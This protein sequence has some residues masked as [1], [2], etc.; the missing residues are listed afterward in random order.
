MSL[1][2]YRILAQRPCHYCGLELSEFGYGI[3]RVDCSKGYELINCV[4][5]CTE[6]NTAKSDN[7]TEEEMVLIGEVIRKIKLARK[8]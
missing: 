3:D 1:D 6:C 5:C 8:K 2:E 7:F 4:P